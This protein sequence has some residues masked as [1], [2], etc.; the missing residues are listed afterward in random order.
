METST[1]GVAQYPR[2][3]AS[4]DRH[5]SLGSPVQLPSVQLP[6]V[7]HENPIPPALFYWGTCL[8]ARINARAF[9]CLLAGLYVRRN[10]CP[11]SMMPFFTRCAFPV[12]AEFC[13]LP[14]MEAWRGCDDGSTDGGSSELSMCLVEP[15]SWCAM[16][17]L[18]ASRCLRHSPTIT[19]RSLPTKLLFCLPIY[20]FLQ[21]PNHEYRPCVKGKGCQGKAP[22]STSTD[23]TSAEVDTHRVGGRDWV[24]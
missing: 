18:P 20:L 8:I 7:R 12:V 23:V 2:P 22:A 9:P 24:L 5:R 4:A 19:G 11:W 14:L 10:C 15:L 3:Q 17:T 1:G 13:R 6:D 21:I 16:L